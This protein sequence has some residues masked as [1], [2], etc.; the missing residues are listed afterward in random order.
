VEIFRNRAELTQMTLKEKVQQIVLLNNKVAVLQDVVT[1]VKRKL[2]EEFE[3]KLKMKDDEHKQKFSHVEKEY[4]KAQELFKAEIAE[5]RKVIKNLRADLEVEKRESQ[6]VLVAVSK[7]ELKLG[8]QIKAL[9]SE[10]LDMDQALQSA[11]SKVKQLE[12]L[13]AAREDKIRDQKASVEKMKIIVEKEAEVLKKKLQVALSDSEIAEKDRRESLEIAT[14]AIKAAEKREKKL[15]QKVE[16]LNG[17]IA[18]M[19]VRESQNRSENEIDKSQMN[20][21]EELSRLKQELV[22]EKIANAAKRK[23]EQGRFEAKLSAERQLHLEELKTL[24][25]KLQDKKEPQETAK[26]GRIRRTWKSFKR[27]FKVGRNN[28]EKS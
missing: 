1:R 16:D 3:E 9:K 13:L 2:K 21:K 23:T 22:N 24:Q 12:Q 11:Q 28:S 14:A 7:T 6:R 4:N 17:E 20:M 18:T 15:S 10:V 5:Q 19:R 27:I 26:P 8:D 25:S